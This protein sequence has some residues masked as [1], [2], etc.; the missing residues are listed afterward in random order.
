MNEIQLQIHLN[1]IQMM[2]FGE[3]EYVLLNGKIKMMQIL[4][5][6]L[7]QLLNYLIT[8]VQLV[9]YLLESFQIIQL[10]LKYG[11]IF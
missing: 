11:E 9:V 6:I 5:I 8:F 2:K 4:L 10:Q 1:L 7:N 3:E